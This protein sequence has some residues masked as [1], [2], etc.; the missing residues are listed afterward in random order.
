MPADPVAAPGDPDAGEPKPDGVTPPARG[1]GAIAQAASWQL[2]A[3]LMPLVVNLALTPFVISELGRTRYG[4]WLIASTLTQFIAQ[5]DGGIGRT[6]L[7]FFSGY[8]G[9]GDRP[10]AGRLLRSLLVAVALI[11]CLTLVP[12]FTFAESIAGFF[13]TPRQFVRETVFLIKTL[14]VLVGLAFA[15]NLFAA[16]LNAHHRFAWTSITILIGYV[17]YSVGLV[18]AIGVFDLGLIGMAY[19][20][21]AQQVVA[22]ALIV[23]PALRYVRWAAPFFVDIGLARRFVAVA[24]RIQLSG[25]LTMLSFQGVTLI[26]GRLRAPEVADFGPGATF[27]QQLRMIPTNAL[28]PV[29]ARLGQQVGG[30]S[31]QAA[32]D[33]ANRVQRVWVRGI[34]GWVAVGAPAAYFA[35]GVWLPLGNDLAG[36]VAATLLVAHLF[37]LLPQVLVQWAIVSRVPGIETAASAVTSVVTVAGSLALVPVVGAWGVGIATVAAQVIGLIVLLV[38]AGRAGL[39]LASPLRSVPVVTGAVAA[40]ATVGLELVMVSAIHALELPQGPVGL[41]LCGLAAAPAFI[42]YVLVVFGPRQVL[43]HLPTRRPWRGRIRRASRDA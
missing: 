19:V 3:Q 10:A 21:T 36:L 4:L 13:H 9:S 12:A 14:V 23:P 32:R 26:V 25:L 6:A 29:Q 38:L 24:W 30:E 27:A 40:A 41:L 1:L 20:F 8:A 22:T 11:T 34:V 42:G 39:G 43:R 17:I 7:S 18:L 33:E 28:A 15:R 5:V 31:V 2:L 35:L 16:V 37:A